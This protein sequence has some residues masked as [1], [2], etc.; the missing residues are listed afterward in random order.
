[1]LKP[2]NNLSNR[3]LRIF[4]TEFYFKKVGRQRENDDGNFPCV[5]YDRI[6]NDYKEVTIFKQHLLRITYEENISKNFHSM[7]INFKQAG[8]ESA[9]YLIT[10]SNI[11]KLDTVFFSLTYLYRQSIELILKARVF[12]IIKKPDEQKRFMEEYGHSLDEIFDFI[13]LNT[14]EKYISLNSFIWLEQFLNSIAKID[15]SSD[16]F[17]YPFRIT[18]DPWSNTFSYDYVFKERKDIC[19]EKLVNKL[20]IAF[21]LIND[22]Y[23]INESSEVLQ[24]SPLLESTIEYSVEFLEEGGEYYAKSVIGHEYNNSELYLYIQSYQAAADYLYK[25]TLK[26][27]FIGKET[28]YGLYNTFYLPI[29]YLYRNAIELSIKSL[30]FTIMGY[31]DPLKF[32]YNKKH[33]LIGIWGYIKDNYK[34]NLHIDIPNDHKKEI[35]KVLGLVYEADSSS[36]KFRYPTDK[37]LSYSYNNNSNVHLSYDYHTLQHCLDLID[38]LTDMTREHINNFEAY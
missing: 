13:K 3:K 8:R 30:C 34:S 7:A 27:L 24:L 26:N 36:S 23:M 5:V 28:E 10:D 4:D 17:R 20:E 19:L 6:L 14:E 1:M 12:Q 16:S 9:N 25:L 18:K 38:F 11:G 32:L 37:H 29:C 2:F 33:N 35:D 22:L 31:K 21:N 15:R